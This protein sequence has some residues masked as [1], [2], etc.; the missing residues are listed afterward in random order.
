MLIAVATS[1]Q[2]KYDAS[3]AVYVQSYIYI[4]AINMYIPS[5]RLF[6]CKLQPHYSM[7]TIVLCNSTTAIN[8]KQ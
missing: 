5:A 7:L 1:M 4:Y 2:Y 8:S 3:D 6:F